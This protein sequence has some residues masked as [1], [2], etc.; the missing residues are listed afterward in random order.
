M[1]PSRWFWPFSS[2][3]Q[4]GWLSAGVANLDPTR[5]RARVF[6][7]RGQGVVFSRGLGVLCG[8]LR[9]SGLWAE[10]LRCVGDAWVLHHLKKER[11]AG[12]LMFVGHSCGGRAALYAARELEKIG[13]PVELLICLDVAVPPEV[14][15]NVR[16]AVNISRSRW[17]IY[18]AGTLRAAPGS[19]AQIDNIDLD[20]P[21]P[22]R[23]LHHLNFTD[24][25]MVQ[26]MVLGRIFEVLDTTSRLG[27]RSA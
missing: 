9:R 14:P 18:P 6:L 7:L 2:G 8:V 1:R 22:M 3:V 24:S 23:G 12:P 13:V 5:A 16:R 11:P 20:Q 4:L 25:P 27:M 10:D 17:R 19:T 21:V 26:A 15:G